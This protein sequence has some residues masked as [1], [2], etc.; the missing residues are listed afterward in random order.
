VRKPAGAA[1]LFEPLE[2]QTLATQVYARIL[3]AIRTGPLKPGDRL[4]ETDLAESLQVSRASVREALRM[5]QSKG[6]VV[7]SHRRGTFVAEI[8]AAD[9]R[10]IYTLRS[11]LEG[12][13]VRVLAERGTAADLADLQRC[14]DELRLAG[15]RR[16]YERIVELDLRFHR[17][18]CASLGNWRLLETWTSMVTQLRALL[19]TKYDLY[20]DSPAIAESHARLLDAVRS[21]DAAGAERMVQEHIVETAEKV[22]RLLEDSAGDARQ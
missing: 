7:S 13:A 15:E 8:N 2:T 20:D 22:L 10:E 4:I 5:L 12:Y 17:D 9:A 3:E 11:L 21:R 1:R 14:V 18:V 19:L 6:L 16:D